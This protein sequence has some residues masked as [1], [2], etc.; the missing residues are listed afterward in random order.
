MLIRL[1][2]RQQEELV[3]ELCG[4]SYSRGYTYRRGSSYTKTLITGIGMVRFRVKK[5]IRRIDNTVRSP[6]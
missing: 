6:I 5:V 1:I 2:E 3:D 4:P